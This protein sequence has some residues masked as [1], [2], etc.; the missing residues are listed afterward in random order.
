MV[1][2]G[3]GPARARLRSGPSRRR[4]SSACSAAPSWPRTTPRPTCSC[5]RACPTPSATSCMEALASG[6]PVVSFAVAA[7]AE[8]VEDGVS[9]RLVAPGDEAA[10]IA[11]VGVDRPAPAPLSTPMRAAALAAARRATWPEV[12]GALRGPPGRHRSMHPKRP[13]HTSPSWP[14]Q[15]LIWVERERSF[16][17]WM[18][19]AATRAW[20]VRLLARG[21]PLRR[22]LALVRGHRQPAVGRRRRSAPR[23]RCG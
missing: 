12:L 9:G 16:A 18:H 2:V 22:R 17:L 23:P 7:A 21:Q 13:R 19:G 15:Q 11:A 4:A 1:V 8:H 6:L 5:S 3:D 10:F 20:V 14:E